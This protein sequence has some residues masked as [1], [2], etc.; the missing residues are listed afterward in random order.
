MFDNQM[1]NEKLTGRDEAPAKSPSVCSALLCGTIGFG[2]QA[3]T[4]FS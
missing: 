4:L 2:A 3:G 1:P